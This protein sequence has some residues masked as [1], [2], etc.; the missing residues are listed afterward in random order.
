MTAI[1]VRDL[2]KTYQGVPAVN[3]IS[4]TARPER[5]TGFLGPNGAGKTTTLRCLL[6]LAVPDAGEGTVGGRR[7]VSLT[8]PV[9]TVGTVLEATSFHPGRTA[10]AHLRVLC[11]AAGLPHSR[12]EEVL[13]E[14]ELATAARKRVGTFSMGMRQRLA[15][16]SALLGDPDVLILDEPA[17]GLDPAGIQWLRRFL[18]TQ[19]HERGTTVLVSSHLLAE[20]EQTVDDVVIISRGELVQQGTLA[21]VTQGEESLQGVFLRLTGATTDGMEGSEQ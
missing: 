12:V 1:E 8:S 9:S 5:V 4:F 11:S 18:T 14:V 20:V 10:R 17:N 19:A 6:G 2:R 15:L 3:G 16:A 13:A 7:Y 21:D